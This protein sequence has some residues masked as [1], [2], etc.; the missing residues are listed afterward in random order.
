[1]ANKNRTL[2]ALR[3]WLKPEP[4]KTKQKVSEVIPLEENEENEK[5]F[6]LFKVKRFQFS[7]GACYDIDKG[8]EKIPPFVY[9]YVGKQGIHHCFREIYG[10]WSR[11]FTDQQLIGKTIRE[12]RM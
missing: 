7:T 5:L 2:N 3:E 6:S 1:M 9:R 11:T 8:S 4:K 10:G 12:V